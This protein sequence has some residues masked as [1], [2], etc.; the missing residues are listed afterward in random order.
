MTAAPFARTTPTLRV[1]H[2]DSGTVPASSA[3]EIADDLRRR[4]LDG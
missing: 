2:G 3:R 1:V 4:I